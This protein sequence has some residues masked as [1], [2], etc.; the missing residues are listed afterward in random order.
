MPS[1]RLLDRASQYLGL[2][3]PDQAPDAPTAKFR[4]PQD[5]T[6]DGVLAPHAAL[7]RRI[8]AVHGYGDRDFS[9][10]LQAPILARILAPSKM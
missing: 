5:L 7:V 8:R 3:G 9:C 4:P 10:H 2:R 1:H 6:A